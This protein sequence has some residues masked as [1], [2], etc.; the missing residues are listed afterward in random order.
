MGKLHEQMKADLTLKGYSLCTSAGYL[1]R[2]RKFAE[3]FNRS[4]EEMGREEI[5]TFLLYLAEEQKA[6]PALQKAYL[7]AL[8]F[9]Y[10]YTLNRPEEV[11][12]LPNPKLPKQL[13]VVLSRQEVLAVFE[14]I[15]Y[16]KQ[17]AMIAT[18]YGK[19]G[20]PCNE[21]KR[22]TL[23]RRCPALGIR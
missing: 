23:P 1:P 8:K 20:Q 17:K 3:H 12:N 13:P 5:R 9:L 21:K 16:I 14:A 15:P 19:G 10:R 4:P 2:C 18:T 6:S 22:A 7:C 11:E